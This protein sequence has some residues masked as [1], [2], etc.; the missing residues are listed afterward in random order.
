[1]SNNK[2]YEFYLFI[3]YKDGTH[4]VKG[5]NSPYIV[6]TKKFRYFKFLRYLPY[7][8]N[9]EEFYVIK[10]LDVTSRFTQ[11][12][13]RCLNK[14]YGYKVYFDTYKHKLIEK[15]LK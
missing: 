15:I 13:D 7:D 5:F 4:K 6:K 14:K 8:E 12:I 1:M 2:Q 10:G 3:F 9:I 11:R